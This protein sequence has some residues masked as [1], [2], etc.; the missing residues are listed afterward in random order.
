M[1]H[2]YRGQ[3][4]LA[5]EGAAV[6]PRAHPLLIFSHG[7]L[8]ASDQSIFLTES[9]ARAGYIVASMNHTDA[10][11]Q[12][13]L[14]PLD[15]PEFGHPRHWDDTKYRDR[16][17]DVTALLDQLLAWNKTVGSPWEGRIAEDAI[18]GVGHSLG[19]YT[20]LAMAGGWPSW[21]EPRLKALVLYSPYAQPFIAKGGPIAIPVLLQ[22][23]TLDIGITPFLPP[24]YRKLGG[25]KAFLV[26]KNESHFAWTNLISLGK[27]TTECVSD[28][29]AGLILTHTLAWLD[30]YLLESNRSDILR[31]RDPRLESYRFEAP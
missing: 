15:K 27:T 24:V 20:L 10:L 4:G 21:K 17:E 7:F 8:G 18:G 12:P 6:A 29:N 22:G 11:A 14:H 23:G 3:A 16:R 2:N 25:P 1:P 9:F 19:G 13:R 28:G 30:H 26:L 31:K 5:A